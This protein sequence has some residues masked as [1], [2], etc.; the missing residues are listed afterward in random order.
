MQATLIA[1]NAARSP[2]QATIVAA[3]A[4][5]ASHAVEARERLRGRR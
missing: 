1:A 2:F 5:D 4:A 3:T